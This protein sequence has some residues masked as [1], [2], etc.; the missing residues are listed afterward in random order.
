MANYK[1]FAKDLCSD[2]FSAILKFQY[3]VDRQIF[4]YTGLETPLLKE[5]RKYQG[6]RIQRELNR[7]H[8]TNFQYGY[9]ND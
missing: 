1:Q 9:I 4:F 5:A 6:K 8:G 7:A 3:A 2:I